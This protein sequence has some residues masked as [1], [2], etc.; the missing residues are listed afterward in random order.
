MQNA[1]LMGIW[2]LVFVLLAINIQIGTLAPQCR[3]LLFYC[4]VCLTAGADAAASYRRDFRQAAVHS[5]RASISNGVRY[6]GDVHSALR[7]VSAVSLSGCDRDP[8][9][10]ARQHLL[11]FERAVRLRLFAD[12]HHLDVQQTSFAWGLCRHWAARPARLFRCI[13]RVSNSC[14]LH[15][16]SAHRNRC[17]FVHKVLIVVKSPSLENLNTSRVEATLSKK[18]SMG[19]A[20]ENYVQTEYM[21]N[22]FCE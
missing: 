20:L 15:I 22:H 13:E 17:C 9:A 16:T 7:H 1:L 10:N 3:F 11:L 18:V 8:N 21:R 6:V 5:F 14:Y 4:T 19:S 2:F 12:A